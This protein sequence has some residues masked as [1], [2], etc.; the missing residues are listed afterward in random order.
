METAQA[1][2][3]TMPYKYCAYCCSGDDDDEILAA[4][5]DKHNVEFVKVNPADELHMFCNAS[6]ITG[7][8]L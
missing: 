6:P 7:C 2:T 8:L 4:N 1:P 3:Q 5:V